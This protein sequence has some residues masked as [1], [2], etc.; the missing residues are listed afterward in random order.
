MDTKMEL[1]AQAEAL[2]ETLRKEVKL[3]ALYSVAIDICS[4]YKWGCGWSEDDRARFKSDVYPRFRKAGY[5]VVSSGEEDVCDSLKKEG[6][7]LDIY[8][9]PMTFSGNATKEEAEDIIRILGTCKT[10]SVLRVTYKEHYDITDAEYLEFIHRHKKEL[11]D[12][13]RALINTDN[14]HIAVDDYAVPEA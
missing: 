2:R 8:M 12:L 13:L 14:Q 11:M 9:H 4:A 6:S 7:A 3:S 1:F 5:E 10:C